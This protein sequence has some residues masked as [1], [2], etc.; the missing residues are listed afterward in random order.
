MFKIY[1]CP[2]F[3]SSIK[4]LFINNFNSLAQKNDNSTTCF[5]GDKQDEGFYVCEN[6]GQKVYLNDGDTLM[7]CPR[8][9]NK[10]FT[11]E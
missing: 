3:Y 6:C 5:S 11:K 10:T 7:D 8:C 1:S 9:T 2:F 4:S